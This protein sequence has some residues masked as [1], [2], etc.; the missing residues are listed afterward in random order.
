M[1]GRTTVN[2]TNNTILHLRAAYYELLMS[3]S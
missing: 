1:C 2:P 3:A